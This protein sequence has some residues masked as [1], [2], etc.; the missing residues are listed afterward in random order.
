MQNM[1][2]GM[3][4]DKSNTGR[5]AMDADNVT[6]DDGGW[7]Y[8]DLGGGKIEVVSAP[9]TSKLKPGAIIDPANIANM[10]AGAARD[11]A[12]RA[13]QSIVS[14]MNGGKAAAPLA[15]GKKPASAP[16]VGGAQPSAARP[17]ELRG[18]E[19]T[20]ADAPGPGISAVAPPPAVPLPAPGM[21]PR[22]HTTALLNRLN[23]ED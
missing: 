23:S 11:K 21:G 3:A 22:R 16:P 18:G 15:A 10:P 2:G 13:Y 17:G 9:P 1:K 7:A 4:P 19:A 12:Q 5:S 20:P 14:V 6:L 8:R